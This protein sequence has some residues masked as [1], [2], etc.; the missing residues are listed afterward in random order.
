MRCDFRYFSSF[1][2]SAAISIFFSHSLSFFA[3]S[4][5]AYFRSADFFIFFAIFDAAIHFIFFFISHAAF[6]MS[7]LSLIRHYYAISTRRAIH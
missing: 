6:D 4:R 2:I 1:A 7:L 3:L 5:C